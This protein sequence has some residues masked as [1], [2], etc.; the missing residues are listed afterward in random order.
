M[1][2][3]VLDDLYM[4]IEQRIN[5]QL[6][7]FPLVKRVIKRAY[8]SVC[9]AVSKKI[10]SEGNI[11]RLSPNDKE[12][13]YFLDIMTRVLGMRQVATLFVCEPKILG[14]NQI[15]LNRQISY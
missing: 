14:V 13:E 7:K 3:A 11:V 9:Y 6:N 5:Y 1:L 2:L 4:S 10:E 8:Q 12:Y 15:R